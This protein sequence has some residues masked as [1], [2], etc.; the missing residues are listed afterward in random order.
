M[1]VI[2]LP[3]IT[4][5]TVGIGF[6]SF[7]TTPTTTLMVSNNTMIEDPNHVNFFLNQGLNKSIY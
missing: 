3:V 4:V 7:P 6:G 5:A 1:E 2:H